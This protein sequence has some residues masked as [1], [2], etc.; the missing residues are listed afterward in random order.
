MF[1]QRVAFVLIVYL[2]CN[3]VGGNECTIGEIQ[4]KPYPPIYVQYGKAVPSIVKAF[5]LEDQVNS[6]CYIN[7]TEVFAEFKIDRN[8]TVVVGMSFQ[9]PDNVAVDFQTDIDE[10]DYK[11]AICYLFVVKCHF[12]IDGLSRLANFCDAKMINLVQTEITERNDSYIQQAEIPHFLSDA[13][14]L[15]VDTRN[16]YDF[17]VIEQ[18]LEHV[19]DFPVLKELSISNCNITILPNI[20]TEKFPNLESLQISNTSLSEP[21]MFPWTNRI[22]PLPLNLS[23]SPWF[24]DQ[25]S[26]IFHVDIEPNFFGRNLFLQN[27]EI[28]NLT[29]FQFRGFVH[30]INLQNNT[31][32]EIGQE[33]F[34]SVTG[35]QFLNL[36]NN[37]LTYIQDGTFNTLIEL[38]HLDLSSNL[39]T[40]L[41]TAM[42][43]NLLNLKYLTVSNNKLT[44]LSLKQFVNLNNL[45]TLDLSNNFLQIIDNDTFPMYSVDLREV[46]LNSN[47]L[48]RFPIEL[49]Y[50]KSLKHVRLQNSRIREFFSDLQNKVDL[51]LLIHG[52]RETGSDSNYDIFKPPSSPKTIDLSNGTLSDIVFPTNLNDSNIVRKTAIIL[53]HFKIVLDKNPLECDCNLLPLL[54]FVGAMK[55]NKTLK[56]NEYFLKQ[57]TCNQPLELNSRALMSIKPEETLCKENVQFCPQGCSCLKRSKVGTIIVDCRKSSLN[58]LPKRLPEASM[59]EL[60]FQNCNISSIDERAYWE[61]IVHLDLEANNLQYVTPK[62]LTQMKRLRFLNIRSNHIISLPHEL[63][64]VPL[65]SIFLGDNPLLCDCD[66]LWLKRWITSHLNVVKDHDKITCNTEERL[67]HKLI[68]VPDEEFVCKQIP[69]TLG[70]VAA[71]TVFFVIIV[72]CVALLSVYRFEV[73]VLMYYYLG[74]HPFDNYFSDNLEILDLAVIYPG[75]DEDWA[76]DCVLRFLQVGIS[77]IKIFDFN[78]HAVAGFSY[79][80]NMACVVQ[81]S[82]R[83]LVVLTSEFLDSDLLSILWTEAQKKLEKRNNFLLIVTRDINIES[84]SNKD[85]RRYAKRGCLIDSKTLLFQKKLLYQVA[86]TKSSKDSKLETVNIRNKILLAHDTRQSL[87][88]GSNSTPYIF[89]YYPD[90]S[91]NFIKTEVLSKLECKDYH[92]VISD[93][94]FCPATPTRESILRAI[95]ESAHT[96]VFID[97]HSLEDEWMMFTIRSTIQKSIRSKSNNLILVLACELQNV[98]VPDEDIKEYL[99]YNVTLSWTDTR[100]WDKLYMSVVQVKPGFTNSGQIV[101]RKTYDNKCFSPEEISIDV[102]D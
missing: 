21:P 77:N 60:W 50:I 6:S 18:V 76:S 26:K 37:K 102:K 47:P 9:C 35:L 89:L 48:V 19:S 11:N 40:T 66:M 55:I 68:D 30:M 15:A 17:N 23:R 39:L 86:Y 100:F 43:S 91:L 93:R 27:N 88:S 92:V 5:I 24:Q 53:I 20:I 69:N 79:I 34:I 3:T 42:F 56:G 29:S 45:V 84:I 44:T 12:S 96:V 2:F 10:L 63:Q 71:F 90:T 83:L 51:T 85:M 94:D 87:D 57:W 74:F 49:L 28:T 59:M 14:V 1:S 78:T 99:K 58:H 22:E 13:V 64:D 97:E 52:V 4:N 80:D 70:I 41:S 32:T 82:K 46:N 62:S 95:E 25:Y 67:A 8:A 73:K 72:L 98:Y 54:T 31:I 61:S 101:S 33:T 38:R 16:S 36:A 81:H 75:S 65:Q 7:V